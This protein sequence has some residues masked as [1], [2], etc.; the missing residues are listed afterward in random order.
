MHELK[1]KVTN[2]HT[3]PPVLK[4]NQLHQKVERVKQ[5]HTL[6]NIIQDLCG[7]LSNNKEVLCAIRKLNN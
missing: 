6:T 7:V 2:L 1:K 3:K 5:T 4:S